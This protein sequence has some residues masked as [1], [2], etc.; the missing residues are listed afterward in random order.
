M[1][2]NESDL[3]ELPL[4]YGKSRNGEYL[5]AGDSYFKCKIINNTFVLTE[6][7]NPRFDLE[8]YILKYDN[9]KIT[10]N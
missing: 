6:R 9:L 2:V 10:F 8:R 5:I 1:V 7:E 3:S 4:F